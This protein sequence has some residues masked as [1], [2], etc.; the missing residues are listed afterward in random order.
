MT[1]TDAQRRANLKYKKDKMKFLN[2]SFSP[3]DSDLW[4]YLETKSNKAGF[5]KNLIREAMEKGE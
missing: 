3:N 5:V 2:L 1:E 4:E